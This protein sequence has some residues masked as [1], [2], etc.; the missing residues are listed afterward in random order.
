MTYDVCKDGDD[1]IIEHEGEI[2][3]PFTT[4][5]AAISFITYSMEEAYRNA[6]TLY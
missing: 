5:K 1:Y 4:F 2:I 3:G 6:S